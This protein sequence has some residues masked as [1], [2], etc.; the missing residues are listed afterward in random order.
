MNST[1]IELE[2]LQTTQHSL[3]NSSI[4]NNY[5]VKDS[6]H[7]A[8]ENNGEGVEVS[9]PAISNGDIA[10]RTRR[11]LRGPLAPVNNFLTDLETRIIK[12]YHA[13][14][15]PVLI[16]TG[17][18]FLIGYLIYFAFALSLDADRATDLIYVTAFGFFCFIYWLVK[19]FFGKQ[20]SHCCCQPVGNFFIAR[21]R[22]LNWFVYLKLFFF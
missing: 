4:A 3:N 12:F 5:T 20:I 22:I 2:S 16:G 13:Q 19:K 9:V 8:Q 10:N 18:V 7:S 17:V 21:R 1:T 11:V 15:T 14:K 6:L